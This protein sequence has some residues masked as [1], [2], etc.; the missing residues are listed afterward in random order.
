MPLRHRGQLRGRRHTV[1]HLAELRGARG[2]AAS[3]SAIRSA[4][5]RPSPRPAMGAFTHEAAA[6]DVVN[7]CIYLTEDR[8]DGALYRFV[9][10][11]WGDLSEG[12]LQVLTETAGVLGWGTVPD[13]DG[14]PVPT[15]NQV[16]GTKRF[17][18]GE[19]AA[20]SRRPARVHDQGRQPRLD[21]R[22]GRQ[23]AD[24]RVRRRHAG[25]RRAHRRRQRGDLRTRRD[26]RGRG[27]RG[28]AD[29]ARAGDGTR[30]SP[31]WSSRA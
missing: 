7:R 11:T 14:I 9:P 13:P 21:L 28:H 31:S 1:G 16:A 6:A 19:G 23:H 10:T 25:E 8:P 18:G 24:D 3:G 30:P 29:R 22:P 4:P 2:W 27:R 15:R 5:S 17:A 12:P 20:M 26:L